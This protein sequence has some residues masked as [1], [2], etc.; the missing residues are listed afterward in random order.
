MKYSVAMATGLSSVVM[1]AVTGCVPLPIPRGEPS[2]AYGNV[3]ADEAIRAKVLPGQTREEV[4]QQLGSPSYD[5]GTGRAFVYPWTVDKGSI[6]ILLPGGAL[7]SSAWADARLFMIA[8]DDDGHALKTG[9]AEMISYRSVS[10]VVRRWMA[11]QKLDTVIRPQHGS[12]RSTI[13][14][15][16]RASAPCNAR[17]HAVEPY[18]P[19]APTI[20]IDGQMVGDALKGEFLRLS[21]APGDHLVVVEPVSPF[22]RVEFES[23]AVNKAGPA[24]LKVRIE[25]GQTMHAETW[26]C[27]EADQ[28][29]PYDRRFMRYQMHLELR[30]SEL[31]GAELTKLTSA[32]P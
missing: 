24:S 6:V 21:V 30:D 12:H 32:W 31:A 16:R 5:F 20:A 11:E 13:V 3:I 7:I 29:I 27:L 10:G 8:F 18:S 17:Q 28:A 1:F 19:F 9:T 15:Y 23:F 26:L 22:Q 14:V 25:P 2:V 4:I